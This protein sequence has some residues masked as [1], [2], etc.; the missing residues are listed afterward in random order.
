MG[1]SATSPQG[2]AGSFAYLS[3]SQLIFAVAGMVLT[4]LTAAMIQAFGGTVMPRAIASLNGFARYSWTTTFF[5][6]T[7]TI[8]MPVFAKLSDLYGRKWLYVGSTVIFVVS[9]LLCGTAGNLPLPLDGMN[10]LI[11]AEGL[12]GIGNGAIIAITFTLVADLFPPSERGRYQGLMAAVFGVAF[13]I[14]PPVGGWITDHLSWRWAYYIDV[15]LGVLAIAVVYFALPDV[16]P[17]SL[18]PRQV[19]RAE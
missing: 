4:L 18:R 2:E 3:R 13:T 1:T 6:L 10:Q 17:Q 7:T 8:A 14:G 5:L 9:L 16:R 11:V 15:P 12:L 19:R